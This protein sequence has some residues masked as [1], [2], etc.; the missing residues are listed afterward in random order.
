ML[1]GRCTERAWRELNKETMRGEYAKNY[2]Y[3]QI[4]VYVYICNFSNKYIVYDQN[5]LY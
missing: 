5:I 4:Y 3:L 1:E 2:L